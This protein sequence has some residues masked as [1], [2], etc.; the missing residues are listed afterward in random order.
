MSL[1]IVGASEV[2]YQWR[3]RFQS[4]CKTPQREQGGGLT[5]LEK[6]LGGQPERAVPL[7]NSRVWTRP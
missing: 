4:E 7:Q 3:S 5:L 2:L 6:L 1:Y